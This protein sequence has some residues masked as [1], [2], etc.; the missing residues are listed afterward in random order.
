[1]SPKRDKV[2]SIEQAARQLAEAKLAYDAAVLRE[3]Y[4]VRVAATEPKSS[5]R[6]VKFTHKY[7]GRDFYYAAIRADHYRGARRWFL[8]SND[9]I[10]QSGHRGVDSP[11]TWVELVAFA[12]PDTIRVA[13]LVAH[14]IPVQLPVGNPGAGQTSSTVDDEDDDGDYDGNYSDDIHPSD[15]Y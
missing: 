8:T 7:D 2:P 3:S 4:E 14:W 12:T 1:M 11:C 6:V 5:G 10:A 13:P 15:I 9:V